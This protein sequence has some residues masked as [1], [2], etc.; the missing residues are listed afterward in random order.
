MVI[1]PTKYYSLHHS[2][3]LFNI[4]GTPDVKLFSKPMALIL[5]C[6]YLLK[7]F[8][9]SVSIFTGFIFKETKL[10][11]CLNRIISFF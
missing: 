4:Q 5:L 6:K 3:V 7:A 1:N 10:R 9:C 11:T 2:C 8:V